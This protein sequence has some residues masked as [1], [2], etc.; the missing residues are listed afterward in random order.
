MAT[1]EKWRHFEPL[2]ADMAE[3][4]SRLDDL[5]VGEGVL[6]AYLFGS[7]LQESRPAQ[8]VDLA[9]L[10]PEDKRPYHLHPAIIACLGTE[11]VDIVDLRRASPV[12]KFEI[13]SNG[14]C[15]Y[16]QNEDIQFEFVMATLRQ[17][18]DTNY[19]RQQQDKILRQRLTTTV[20]S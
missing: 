10:L 7:L 4:L 8:D 9:L 18:H 12:L 1:A 11:R 14:R 15:L 17:Y 19:L 6:L 13:I 5:F 2:P 20:D 3:R 16:T